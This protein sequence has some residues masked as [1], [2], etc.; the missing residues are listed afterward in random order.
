[1]SWSVEPGMHV[2]IVRNEWL[3]GFQTV[4]AQVREDLGRLVVDSAEPETWRPI[5]LGSP[6]REPETGELVEAEK[7]PGRFLQLLP[8]AIH[9]AYLFATEAHAEDRCPFA[10]RPLIP[11]RSAPDP[12]SST[13]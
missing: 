7:E 10:K 13:A 3:A 9:S 6:V 2:D 12:S 5:V 1:M 4:V 8:R 11:I